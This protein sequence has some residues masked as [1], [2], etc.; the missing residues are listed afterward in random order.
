M[1][2]IYD[3][4]HSETPQHIDETISWLPGVIPMSL[5]EWRPEIARMIEEAEADLRYGHLLGER[6][7]VQYYPAGWYTGTVIKDKDNGY[8][9]DPETLDPKDDEAI[10]VLE[11]AHNIPAIMG[12]DSDVV[13]PGAECPKCGENRVDY[14]ENDGEGRVTCATCNNVYDI[15]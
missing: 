1:V 13:Y 4:E 8:M 10:C 6:I 15:S 12:D 2:N 9:L 7:R 3:E 11:Y 14:L 5:D